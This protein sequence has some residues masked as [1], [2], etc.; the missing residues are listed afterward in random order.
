LL[1]NAGT[2]FRHKKHGYKGV[3]YAWDKQCDRYATCK[4]IF[5]Q[6][7]TALLT[8]NEQAHA[9]AIALLRVHQRYLLCKQ[10]QSAYASV[11]ASCIQLSTACC[12]YRPPAWAHEL[13]VKHDQPFYSVLPDEHDC[14][15]LFQGGRTS[16]YVAQVRSLDIVTNTHTYSHAP[17]LMQA[18]CSILLHAHCY[19]A[20][21]YIAS[22]QAYYAILSVCAGEC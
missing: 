20:F 16:K 11:S 9:F 22:Q 3:I 4:C 18:T 6:R 2:V 12:W 5:N 8:C 13:Q 1:G 10:L 17:A 19:L 21:A 14:V 7:Q 15:R